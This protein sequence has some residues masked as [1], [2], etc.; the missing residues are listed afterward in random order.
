M[1]R[2]LILLFILGVASIG[3]AQN[4]PNG[5]FES[6]EIRDHFK[7]A[8][9]NSPTRNVERSTDAKE[10]KYSLKLS[11]TYIENSTGYR[12]YANN[13]D[14]TIDLNGYAFSGDAYSLV[15]WSK[16]D[17]AQGD[18]ARVYAVFRDK[19]T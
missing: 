10:G 11:N 4:I 5:D 12:G 3:Y 13:I 18:T 16:H 14:K 8:N 2:I 15:F 19:G 17:L 7:L 9:Y 1:N 6:W